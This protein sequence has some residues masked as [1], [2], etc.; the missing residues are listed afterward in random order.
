MKPTLC[1]FLLVGSCL[2]VDAAGGLEWVGNA[3]LRLGVGRT[4]GLPSAIETQVGKRIV[5][6]LGSPVRFTLTNEVTH[7]ATTSLN[8]LAVH[9]EGHGLRVESIGTTPTFTQHWLPTQR[10]LEWTI[11]FEAAAP[12]TG[13]ELT[14]D[15]PLLRPGMKVFTPSQRGV[16]DLA[17]YPQ[18]HAA[19]Y[20]ATAW[21]TG[22]TYVLPLV[23]VLD[24]KTDSALTLALPASDNIPHFQVEWNGPTL[25]LRMAHRGIGD[26]RASKLTILIYSHP[27]DYRAALRAYSD[28]FPA[29]FRPGLARGKAEGTFYYHHIQSHP[30]FAEMVRQNVRYL[31][32]SFWFTHLGEYLPDAAEWEPYTYAR[33]WNLKQ[34]MSDTKI[35]AFVSDLKEHG[36]G[37]YAYFNVTEYGGMGGRSGDASEAAQALKKRFPD[38]LIK[39]EKGEDIP[40]WEG[41]MAMNPGNRYALWPF[42]ADQVQRH[43]KRLPGIEGFVIDRLDWASTIDYGHD[44][45]LT[46]LGA[47]PAENMARPVAEAV[48]GVCLLAHTAGK[49]VFVNQFYKVEVLRDVDGYCHECDYLPALGY[50]SPFRPAS[51]WHQQKPYGDN[52]LA[53]EAQLKRRL[54]WALFPQMIA[55]R[56]PISQQAAS[57]L[58]ADLLELYAPLFDTLKGKEQV[59]EAHCIENSRENDANLFRVPGGRYVAAVTSRTRF[60]TRGDAQTGSAA[61]RLRLAD[62]AS[63]RWAHVIRLGASPVKARIVHA[64]GRLRVSWNGQGTASMVVIGS[65]PEPPL[66]ADKRL[67]NLCAKR[68]PASRTA[69]TTTPRPAVGKLR[70]L[71]LR[72]AGTQVGSQGIVRLTVANRAPISFTGPTIEAPLGGRLP[73]RLPYLRAATGDEGTWFVPDS[74]ELLADTKDG[75]TVRMALAGSDLKLRWCRPVKYSSRYVKRESTGTGAWRGRYGNRASWIPGEGDKDQNG[76]RLTTGTLFVWAESTSDVRALVDREGRRRATCWFAPVDVPVSLTPPDAKPYLVTLYIVDFDRNGR[77]LEVAAGAGGVVRVSKHETAGGIYLTWR[78]EGP[79]EARIRKVE[80]F[81]AVLSGVFVDPVRQLTG[82]H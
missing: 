74:A 78:V 7:R 22:E 11:S 3:S 37:T 61:L 60:L 35:N 79:F 14:L 55:H 40:T 67:A 12:R 54:Q 69:I 9:K 81:N 24:P 68:F 23:S 36:I 20:G 17:A 58:A 77:S 47:R 53:F 51:A 75:N 72:V 2:L 64:A 6:W 44:D 18:Y 48:Q 26:G 27:A 34:T 71:R 56:F 49:R 13:Y 33:W 63:L 19:P 45:R 41:A 46:T 16:M 25:R 15:F 43:L 57:P 73:D 29:Y 62:A 65:G 70:T 38:A 42:L 4:A 76:F 50:L 30:D 1:L 66:A 8:S 80:G 52:L 10:G 59:L 32:S 21:T 31:W 82:G 28:D 5:H 39:N